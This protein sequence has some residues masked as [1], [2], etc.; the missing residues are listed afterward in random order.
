MTVKSQDATNQRR[1]PNTGELEARYD[2]PYLFKVDSILYLIDTSDVDQDGNYLGRAPGFFSA[3]GK[4]SEHPYAYELR[5]NEV[6]SFQIGFLIG[7]RA[8]GS[9]RNPANLIAC[10]QANSLDNAVWFDLNLEEIS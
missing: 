5:P 8:D 9:P 10:T 1:N 6:I 7:N 4:R 3:Y 2:N